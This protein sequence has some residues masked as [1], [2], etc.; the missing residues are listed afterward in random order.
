MSQ[1][2]RQPAL[3]DPR[4]PRHDQHAGAAVTLRLLQLAAQHR[5]HVVAID[6]RAPRYGRRPLRQPERLER[7]QGLRLAFRSA[8]PSDRLDRPIARRHVHQD[9]TTR[10]KAGQ[11][12]RRV[13]RVADD[14]EAGRL[15]RGRHHDLAGVDARVHLREE[16]AR[17]TG[18]QRTD[19]VPHI[20]RRA[21]RTLRVVLV[22]HGHAEDGHEPVALDLRH[23]AAIGLH[24]RLELGHRRAQ[25]AV[26][27]LRIERFRERREPR[28]VGEQHGNEL[29]FAPT[30]ARGPA[31]GGGCVR[32]Q[33]AEGRIAL[34]ARS[35]S[36]VDV[37]PMPGRSRNARTRSRTSSIVSA[38]RSTRR[39]KSGA[40]TTAAP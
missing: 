15:V 33:L 31:T 10:R 39:S 21:H 19:T 38:P 29:P 6:E 11:A 12:R 5:Q 1:L 32:R 26:D 13:H 27:L 3:A 23:G 22:G 20:E 24:D 28:Q 30:P 40:V 8:Q 7:G 2:L 16:D 18:V 17:A 35:A 36:A 4:I 37:R 14:R 34:F 25:E 9:V